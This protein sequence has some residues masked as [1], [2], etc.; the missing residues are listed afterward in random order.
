MIVHIQTQRS[1]DPVGREDQK[2][3]YQSIS[4]L[5]T[6]RKLL[7]YHSEHTEHRKSDSESESE[8][9]LEYAESNNLLQLEPSS[10]AGVPLDLSP[11]NLTSQIQ[12]SETTLIEADPFLEGMST[13]IVI[14][15]PPAPPREPPPP[16][17]PAP[18]VVSM[19]DS[20]K[21]AKFD[22]KKF[23]GKKDEAEEFVTNLELY[24]KLNPTCFTENE[25]QDC[26]RSW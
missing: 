12:N 5:R 11:I 18:P 3:I 20:P 8:D 15:K 24:F 2:K 26:I 21:G 13:A 6:P 14:T 7:H 25:N 23:T 10:N 17:P 1:P 16:P 9:Q 19:T 4:E 22:I